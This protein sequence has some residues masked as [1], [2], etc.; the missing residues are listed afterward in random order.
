MRFD[1][2]IIER[3]TEIDKYLNENDIVIDKLLLNNRTKTIQEVYK[4]IADMLIKIFSKT[5]TK[6]KTDFY[7]EI[8]KNIPKEKIRRLR[9]IRQ[10]D[11]CYFLNVGTLYDMEDLPAVPVDL[12]NEKLGEEETFKLLK[13][14][15]L[16]A[17]NFVRDSK[18]LNEYE[19]D[20]NRLLRYF[21]KDN[22]EE[23]KREP[24]KFINDILA[25]VKKE[26]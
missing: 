19:D 23:T 8:E 6:V 26:G 13:Y 2:E 15:I 12:V 22:I 17:R 1:R 24:L 14:T 21:N 7:A 20:V 5:Y 18:K 11:K 3:Y 10:Y 9:A 16:K 25:E 4:Y